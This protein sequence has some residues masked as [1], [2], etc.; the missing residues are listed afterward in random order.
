[1]Q[2]FLCVLS[3]FNISV[4]PIPSDDPSVSASQWNAARQKPAILSVGAAVTL[5]LL[6][7]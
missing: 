1:L 4:R 5:F 2:L 3:I 6:V 7:R